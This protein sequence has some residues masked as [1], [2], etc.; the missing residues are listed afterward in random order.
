MKKLGDTLDSLSFDAFAA[1]SEV[2]DL[3]E[4]VIALGLAAEDGII[5]HENFAI[6]CY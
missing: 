5:L 1:R 3:P 2:R 6:L 4:G